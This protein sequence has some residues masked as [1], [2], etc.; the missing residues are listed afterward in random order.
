MSARSVALT[1]AVV[2]ATARPAATRSGE[3]FLSA[4]LL[5]SAAPAVAGASVTV[6]GLNFNPGGVFDA[7]AGKKLPIKSYLT[8]S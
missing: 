6:V 5:P 2:L 7:L 8:L 4:A 3:D 1:L